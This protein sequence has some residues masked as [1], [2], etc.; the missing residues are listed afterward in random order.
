SNNKTSELILSKRLSSG[1]MKIPADGIV[2]M[3]RG[4]VNPTNPSEP[5]YQILAEAKIPD[6]IQK[7]LVILVP[8]TKRG[9]DWVFATKVQ[10]LDDFSGGDWLFLNLTQLDVAAK[11]GDQSIPLKPGK[12]RV[13]KAGALREPTSMPMSYHFYEPTQKEW[14][15]I[16]ASTVVVR[17]TRREICIFSWD[18]CR[19]RIKYHGV[20]FPVDR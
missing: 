19:K 9:T 2:R 15:L 4:Q 8:A 12:S 16:S 5:T 10:N 17:P 18:E 3:I 6:S 1:P 7:A 11:L 14:K 20:T 13:A